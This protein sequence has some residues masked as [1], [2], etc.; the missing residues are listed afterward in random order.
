MTRRPNL[1]RAAAGVVLAL[2]AIVFGLQA[3]LAWVIIGILPVAA[4]L[5]LLFIKEPPKP[6]QGVRIP[7]KEGLK[8]VWRKELR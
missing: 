7:L 8:L 3:A 6:A 1:L 2:L 4:F 5:V